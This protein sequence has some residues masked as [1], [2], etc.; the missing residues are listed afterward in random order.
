MNFRRE[1][2][3]LVAEANTIGSI[4]VIRSLGR[5]G[6]PVF[7]YSANENA[8][9][10][11]SN[12]LSEGLKAPAYSESEHFLEWL[13]STVARYR[14]RV[15]IPSE[16]LLLAL[17]PAFAEFSH[18]LPLH[19]DQQVVYTGM[20][21]FDLFARFVEV[22]G[23]LLNNLPPFELV[24]GDLPSNLKL[25]HNL[26]QA[27]YAK[28]DACYSH[29]GNGKV[30][31]LAGGSGFRDRIAEL[32]QAECPKILLQGHVPG[33]GVGIFLLRWNG[34]ILASFGHQRL[35][36]VPH[37]GGASS[38][39]CSWW[40]EEIY[41]DALRRLECLNWQGVAMLEYRYDA[42]TGRFYLMEMNGRFWGSLHLALFAGVDFP[43]LM[44]DA[45]HGRAE[46]VVSNGRSV[47]CRLTFPKELE[48]ILSCV[49]DAS[50]PIRQRLWPMFEFFVLAL[51]PRVK[52]D[53]FF[54]GDR[55]L[56]FRSIPR[57]IRR[58]FQ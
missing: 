43:R 52:S 32:T 20:S 48:Y 7:A 13:R 46:Q 37:T 5:A 56:Y 2:P 18:L 39:R 49:K 38:Y 24:T 14:I 22:G 12:Y 57:A 8:L 41:N 23:P 47:S 36:E 34:K 53:L 21:K 16:A 35:H 6:Y 33:R 55:M 30:I 58:F 50:L 17:R 40:D 9:G 1:L 31:A 10:F 28:I 45:F 29:E 19:Q 54:P 42:E 3:V 26:E 15:L 44:L 51:D 25:G 11:R 4:A 27:V